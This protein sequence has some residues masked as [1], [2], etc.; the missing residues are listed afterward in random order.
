VVQV[1]KVVRNRLPNV[2]TA[3]LGQAI[4]GVTASTTVPMGSDAAAPPST[5]EGIVYRVRCSRLRVLEGARHLT[6]QERPKVITD[7]RTNVAPQH[8]RASRIS[9]REVRA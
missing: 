1:E 3:G 8:C 2:D 4:G 5:A 9:D 6:P 7:L